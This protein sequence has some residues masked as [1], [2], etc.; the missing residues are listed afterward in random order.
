MTSSLTALSSVPAPPS[1]SVGPMALP[2]LSVAPML[3]WT[4]RHARFFLRLLSPGTVLYTEMVTA[5]AVRHGDRA[6]LLA[7]DQSEQPVVLQLGGFDPALMAAAA[8][9]GARWGYRELNI[10]AGCPSDRV[11]AGRFGACLMAEPA[12]VAACLRA[13]QTASRLPVTV[14]TRIGIDD[15]DSWEF[16]YR[17]VAEVADAGCQ[18]LILHA[19]KAWL[20]GLS[21]RENREIPPLC[22]ETVYR[23]KATFPALTVTL[24][25]GV[26][27]AAEALTHLQHCDG[28]MVGRA[29]SENPWAL[30]ELASAVLGEG[31]LG[32]AVGDA[33]VVGRSGAPVNGALP[34]RAAAVAAYR[35]YV[36]AHLAAGVPLRPLLRP[37]LGLYQGEPGARA[38][39]RAL[40]VFDAT[41]GVAVLD[42]ALAACADTHKQ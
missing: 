41:A 6:R 5:Q 32:G 35:P 8:E 33:G 15:W 31:I 1:Q 21:P 40:S 4:D 16:L 23:I 36:V 38:W 37:L 18:H 7:F 26:R 2:R 42:Q 19:R 3:D 13:M 17:F 22:Y 25:G 28:V 27:T 29:V 34:T 12:T 20:R 10:N 30:R 11:Q 14:K 24:N 9:A 39:R